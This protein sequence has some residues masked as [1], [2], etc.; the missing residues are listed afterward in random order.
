MVASEL[1]PHIEIRLLGIDAQNVS[2]YTVDRPHGTEDYLLE[3][4]DTSVD[5]IDV[6]G[7]RRFDGGVLI[8]YG[9]GQ[10]Q[11]FRAHGPLRHTWVQLSGPGVEECI[12]RYSI[13][14]GRAIEIGRP[15]Y[16]NALLDEARGQM[17]HRQGPSRL[18]GHWEDAV[19]EACRTLFRKLA[20]TLY[21]PAVT[22]PSPYEKQQ[23]ALLHRV[24]SQVFKN[25]RRRWTVD[26]MASLASM[27]APRFAVAYSSYFGTSPID[28]LIDVRLR[29]AE[30]LM[31]ALPIPVS[32]AARLSGFNSASNFH[33]RYRE[34]TGLSPKRQHRLEAPMR[35]DVA[36]A[37][38]LAD[39][40][41]ATRQ[42]ELLYV[43]PIAHWTF[44]EG[45]GGIVDNLRRHPVAAVTGNVERV[46]GFRDG[47]ALHFT[48]DSYAAVPEAVVDTGGSYTV[49]AWVSADR[50]N[51]MTAVSIG[52]DHHGAFY[53]QYIPLEGGF[54][55]A[56]TVSERDPSA[57]FV[58][59]QVEV[60]D[61][62]WYHLTGVHDKEA[63]EIRIYVD[64]ALKGKRP[65]NSAW[66]AEGVT[67]F[68][69]C[70]LLDT[71]IDQWIGR[72]DGVRLYDS[73]LTDAEI[74]R[75]YRL[76]GSATYSGGHD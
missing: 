51:R 26:D 48:G 37:E 3:F 70:R 54:K 4:F 25:L 71:I 12:L 72:I 19:T 62:R 8:L 68:G 59:G 11:Y 55:F 30:L 7:R 41:E 69:A 63:H 49:S 2:G 5:L 74:A 21:Q 34:R 32:D 42:L 39:Y 13:P 28:D 36:D 58:I 46:P 57:R 20:R 50:P 10:R 38:T 60:E 6:D 35:P 43:R 27:S 47:L 18:H 66:T 23:I 40:S 73:A 56:T 44:D 29:H 65:F 14:V 64:G 31:R 75:I 76:D 33:V 67:Y 22:E 17:V 52:S 15:D 61:G 1:L 16:L 53:L 24:R 45:E 9:P